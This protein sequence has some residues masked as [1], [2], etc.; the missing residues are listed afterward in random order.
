MF[1]TTKLGSISCSLRSTS[2]CIYL[3]VI[4]IHQFD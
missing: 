2:I 1:S 3:S 4:I